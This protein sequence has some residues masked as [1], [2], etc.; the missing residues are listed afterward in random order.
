MMSLNEKAQKA[1]SLFSPFIKD[2]IYRNGW[3]ELRKVQIEAAWEIFFTEKNLLLSSETASG[4]TE[5]AL[6][7]VL[8]IM[9]TESP[10]NFVVL[11]ISP[12]KSLINDQFSRME[13]LLD[14]SG[15]PVHRWHGDVSQSHK[16]D[17]LKKPSGLLQITPESLES[18]LIR[19]AN[20]IPRLFGNLS[21]LT[22]FT[23]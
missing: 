21:S 13:L 5:A 7:P 22:K 11:Y 6:F 8:S 14:E 23:L 18:M 20:D 3:N 15:L 10:E 9:E 17:F 16:Q 19:R 12:L 1:Y 4:K 2:Y